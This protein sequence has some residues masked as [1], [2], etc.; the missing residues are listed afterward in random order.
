MNKKTRVLAALQGKPVDRVPMSFWRHFDGE[1]S[2]G[3]RCV[4]S[5][6]SFYKQTQMDFIKVMHDGLVAPCSLDVNH[7]TDLRDYRVQG[8][9]N[10]YIQKFLDRAKGI[11]QSIGDQVYVYANVFAPF[12]LLRRIGDAKLNSYIQQDREAVL[13]ALDV[14]GEELA[15]LCELLVK[16]AGCL[17]IFAAFQGAESN[18]FTPQQFMELVY[19]SDQTM[20]GAAN[21]ASPWNILHFCGWDEIKNQLALW[22][23]YQGCAVNWAIYVEALSLAQGKSYFDNRPVLGGFDNRRGRV[24]YNGTQAEVTAETRQMVADYKAATGS[25]EGLLIGADCSFLTDFDLGHFNWV[26]QALNEII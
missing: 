21:R 14:L 23:G 26:A 10:P 5:H 2:Q 17:G 1:D 6:I 24:L 8:R 20:L 22:R 19:P 3:Q 9:S 18:R 16:E 4:E 25:T 15:L 11:T 13:Y 12:T 7:I